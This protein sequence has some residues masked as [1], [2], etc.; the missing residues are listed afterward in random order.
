[1]FDR[2]EESNPKVS[3]EEVIRLKRTE[4]P[5][6]D[7]WETFDRELRQ[8]TLQALM[9]EEPW[10]RN[11]LKSLLFRV[12]AIGVP[13]A[14]AA[15]FGL[16]LVSNRN[17]PQSTPAAISNGPAYQLVA[18]DQELF[19]P[20]GMMDSMPSSRPMS[21]PVGVPGQVTFF[22]DIVRTSP[23]PQQNF[24][25]VMIPTTFTA[26]SDTDAVFVADPLISD[27]PTVQF[28][29]ASALHYF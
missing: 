3:L 6:A 9:N 16:L 11:L 15:V 1:M 17:Q 21:Q 24:E 13:V 5:S 7:F 29:D 8:K 19:N 12:C 2:I 25:K 26:Q 4:R 28:V 14:A 20:P 10:Q 23:N 27:A 18:G 22:I